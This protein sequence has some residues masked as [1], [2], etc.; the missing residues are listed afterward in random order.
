M[1]V[2]YTFLLLLSSVHSKTIGLDGLTSETRDG[3]TIDLVDNNAVDIET[4]GLPPPALP[5]HR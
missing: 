1:Y 4:N 5:A 3:L 2:L